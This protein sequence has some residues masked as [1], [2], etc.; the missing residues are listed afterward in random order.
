MSRPSEIQTLWGLERATSR[1]HPEPFVQIAW[2]NAKAHSA[3]IISVILPTCWI[4]LMLDLILQL[5][6][7]FWMVQTTNW[8]TQEAI[9]II[10]SWECI[11]T[12]IREKEAKRSTSGYVAFLNRSAVPWSSKRQ[13]SVTQ[14]SCEAE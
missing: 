10:S 1:P 14:S 12:Q 2:W 4:I 7:H 13:T 5:C 9:A 6:S 8:C 3:K 11:Q